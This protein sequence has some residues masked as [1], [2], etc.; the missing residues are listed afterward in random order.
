M[1][2]KDLMEFFAV[3]LLIF[4][5]PVNLAHLPFTVWLVTEQ[6]ETGWG[7]GTNIEMMVLLPWMIQ[8]LSVL[9]LLGA[10]IYEI[11]A[12]KKQY[13]AGLRRAALLLAAVA[14]LQF[15]LTDVFLFY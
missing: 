11:I 14:L 2:R 12:W 9:V 3:L 7:Y 8:A 6:I 10:L 1:K 4:L 13:R 5:I 15:I